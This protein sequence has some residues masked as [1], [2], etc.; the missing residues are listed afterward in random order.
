ME[1]LLVPLVLGTMVFVWFYRRQ[2]LSLKENLKETKENTKPIFDTKEENDM[3]ENKTN[4]DW[5]KSQLEKVQEDTKP[6]NVKTRELMAGILTKLS[7]QWE[8]D[9]TGD[10]VFHYQGG[11]FQTSFCDEAPYLFLYY[12]GIY[13]VEVY[14]KDKMER[15][16]ELVNEMNRRSSL[17]AV[18]VID[19]DNGE[20]WVHIE[21]FFLLI[22]EIPA[23]EEHLQL[24]LKRFFQF[25]HDFVSEMEKE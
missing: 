3:E 19:R 5:A 8:V 24:M 10:L 15:V 25:Q 20:L 1:E 9:E 22:P 18:Y 2:G 21:D 13:S 4:E 7:C 11:V 16:K 12:P 14:Q 17:K 6:V 23:V